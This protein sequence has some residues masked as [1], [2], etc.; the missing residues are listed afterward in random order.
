MRW[1]VG[2]VVGLGIVV[3]VN[4]YVAYLAVSGADAI[5]PTYN[6]EAR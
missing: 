6:S 1:I 2:V 4:A 5:D 3:A